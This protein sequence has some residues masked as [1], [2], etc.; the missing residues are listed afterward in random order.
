MN[1]IWHKYPD[2]KPAASGQYACITIY[3]DNGVS[4]D[5]V[6]YFADS[7]KFNCRVGDDPELEIVPAY[8]ADV[9][10]LISLGGCDM[11][12]ERGDWTPLF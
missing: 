10:E 3:G 6:R 4:I 5:G 8:W 7:G 11:T 12:E 2:E 1:K 9:L